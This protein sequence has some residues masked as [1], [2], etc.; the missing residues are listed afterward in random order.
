MSVILGRQPI[1]DLDSKTYG[2][3]LRYKGSMESVLALLSAVEKPG[4]GKARFDQLTTGKKGIVHVPGPEL[5]N[6]NL[7]RFPGENMIVGIDGSQTPDRH[8]F[9]ACEKLCSEGFTL[10]L[11]THAY[12][13]SWDPILDM[14]SFVRVNSG[15]TSRE[16]A[17][18]M[19]EAYLAKN[20]KVVA[21]N[22]HSP[23]DFIDYREMGYQLFQGYFFSRPGLSNG[24]GFQSTRLA[25]LRLLEKFSQ[26][27]ID[28]SEAE[29]IIKGDPALTLKLMQYVN[30]AALGMRFEI[31]SIRQALAIIGLANLRVW[32]SILAMSNISEDKPNEL[33]RQIITRG[34]FCELLAK[35]LAMEKHRPDLFL[36]GMFSL[37]DGALDQPMEKV[38]EDLPLTMEIRNTLLGKETEFSN[39]LRI[40]AAFEQGDWEVIDR[41]SSARQIEAQELSDLQ[42][43]AILWAENFAQ[44]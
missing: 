25:K 12:N 43:E 17:A 5:D 24:N 4:A 27:D 34:R 10:A 38:I 40:A 6:E 9:T 1:L 14:A 8:L 2:Y 35:P 42:Q 32:V 33:M 28:F 36:T 30:S 37:L 3:E 20:L 41:F 31:R 13:A 26:P 19:A 18:R 16:N 21:G 15:R 29:E 11:D 22:I 39:A 44:A 23:A 7:L